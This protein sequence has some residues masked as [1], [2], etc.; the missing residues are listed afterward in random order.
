MAKPAAR[1]VLLQGLLAAAG[2]VILARS[3]VLQVV[4]H[5][6]WRDRAALR[7]V[8]R[9][10]PARR[11]T[12]YDRNGK[13]LATTEQ[14]FRVSVT[15]RELLD[16]AWLE[17]Q[18]PRLLGVSPERVHQAFAA[19]YAFF[20]G[21]YS[22]EMI[23][24]I[25]NTRGVHLSSVFRRVYPQD[26]TGANL[27]GSLDAGGTAGVEGME[28]A[29][30]TLLRG[31]PGEENAIRDG[32]GHLLDAPGAIV[33]EPVPGKSVYL[34][35]DQELQGIAEA[36]LLKTI[37]EHQAKGG[38]FVIY[39]VKTGEI[40]AAASFTADS[41]T[42]RLR[43][44]SQAFVRPYEPG[45]T[46][47]LF[48]AAAILAH[49]SDTTPVSGENGVWHQQ[50]SRN[51]VRTFT[52]EHKVSGLLGLGEAIK[53]SSNI[54]MS[55]FSLNLKPD[56]QYETLRDFGFGSP[57]LVFPGEDGGTLRRP[58]KW[59][60]VML[61]RPSIATGYFFT[62]TTAHLAAGYGAIGNHG[63][64]MAPTL[65][66]EIRSG[67]DQLLWRHQPT[68]L[69]QAVPD[70]VARH[71]ME[72]LA[73]VTEAGGTGTAAQLDDKRVAGKT[74]T[75]RVHTRASRMADEYRAS[76]VGLYPVEAPQVAMAVMIDRPAGKMYFG[77]QVAAPIIR[78]SLQSAL[79][80]LSSP[81]DGKR[82]ALVRAALR[83]P[84][85]PVVDLESHPVGFPLEA[86]AA[87]DTGY[88]AVPEL[89]GS[90]IRD[91]IF[92][93]HQLGL[94]ARLVGRGRVRS[95]SPAAGDTLPR[96]AA[97]IIRADTLR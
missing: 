57:L 18:L 12:I 59:D 52:D 16:T 96:G 76:F 20:G 78:H 29:L 8:H 93:V 37:K 68:R 13:V 45:S 6:Q 53:Y 30:D 5:A 94:E 56:D 69:R 79:A 77:G 97:V 21:P 67:E 42:G 58:V 27:I 19:P 22:A 2:V 85:A 7:I 74:G 80:L 83:E 64:L 65:V 95:T 66:R 34:T 43:R 25:R 36:E 73:L 60:N 11:G 88:V 86:Q 75:A 46:S 61:A 91:A 33:R 81:I 47:K 51:Y 1:I 89:S 50:V 70:S 82:P 28:S 90:S 54:A 17:Q 71:L 3:V 63:W 35:I 24:P 87:R 62:V 14:R 40:L 10:I 9:A 4:Q 84:S 92:A 23:A 15:I 26:S 32:T 41:L 31:T 39:E 72:Y 38:D 48:T 49:G 55:K 44:S